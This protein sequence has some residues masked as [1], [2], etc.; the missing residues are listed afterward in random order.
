MAPACAVHPGARRCHL[1]TDVPA[2]MIRFRTLTAV[3]RPRRRHTPS[4]L[5]ASLPPSWTAAAAGVIHTDIMKNFIAAEIFPFDAFK[6]GGCTYT[7]Y[8]ALYDGSCLCC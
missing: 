6:D 1:R 4:V 2:H 5:S 3:P 7:W 8:T